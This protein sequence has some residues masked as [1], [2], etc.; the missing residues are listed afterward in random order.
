MSNI[1]NITQSSANVP[2]K[3]LQDIELYPDQNN[4]NSKMKYFSNTCIFEQPLYRV[5]NSDIPNTNANININTDTQYTRNNKSKFDS[6]YFPN[7][8]LEQK[9]NYNP[10]QVF[11]PLIKTSTP[12]DSTSSQLSVQPSC[13]SQAKILNSTKDQKDYGQKI[14]IENDFKGLNVPIKVY[15]PDTLN[16]RLN[17]PEFKST[18]GRSF[19]L[20]NDRRRNLD[21]SEYIRSGSMINTGFGNINNFSKIKYGESTRDI[22]GSLRDVEI[23]RFHFTYRN[24]QHTVYG[25]NPFPQDTRYLN[26]KF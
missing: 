23:D 24:Y 5:N 6:K 7:T 25:S 26:K 9:S 20:V 14:N 13:K 21:H 18:D 22:Q 16:K 17:V 10:T 8:L 15:P 12:F 19:K 11:I 4:L 2:S 1:N 3:R